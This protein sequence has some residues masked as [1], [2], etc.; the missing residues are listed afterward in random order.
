M[1]VKDG[2]GKL[3]GLCVVAGVLV[4]AIMF[5]V[6]GGLGVLS[7]K[8]SDTVNA[9]SADLVK[10]DPP[11]VT[12]VTDRNGKPIATLYDQYRIPA[13]S[14]QISNT[15]KVALISVEDARFYEHGAVDLKGTLRAAIND[16][17]GGATQGAST[18]TQQYVKNYLINVVDRNN[19]AEQAKDQAETLS[20]KLREA[21]IAIQLQQNESK[22]QILTGYLNVVAFSKN[23]YGVGAAAKV[24][25]NTTAAKLTVP[26]AALLAG[27]V[28][29]PITYNPWNH[30]Q[31][32]TKRRNLVLQRMVSQK[33]ISAAEGSKYKASGLGVV[34]SP[35]VPSSSCFGAPAY[36]GFFCNYVTT[37]LA[38]SGMPYEKLRASGDTIKTS[39]DSNLSKIARA[40]ILSQVPQ[41][42]DGVGQAFS[43]VQPG[44]T[45]HQVLAMVSNRIFHT[46]SGNGQKYSN[47]VA[48]P[49]VTFG[50][51]S[52]FKIFT[53][54]AA[55]EQGK[56]GLDTPLPNPR[57]GSFKFPHANK[58]TPLYHPQNDGRYPDPISLR[59]ALA[60]S[61]NVAFVGL[62]LKAGMP[63]VLNMASRLGLRKT[64]QANSVGT[65]PKTAVVTAYAKKNGLAS[66]YNEP[67]SQY[68][69]NQP[70]FTLGDNAVS[71]LEMSNVS[72]TIMSGGVWCPPNPILSITDRRGNPVKVPQL[73][74]EQVITPAVAHTLMQGLSQDTVSGTSAVAARAAHW[75]RPDIGKTGTT[76]TSESVAFVGGVNNYSVASM[77]WADGNHPQTLCPGTPIHLGNCGHGA[78]GGTVAA[79][80][81]FNT[82]NKVL[83]GKPNKPIPPAD[84]SML[85]AQPHGPIVPY[86]YLQNAEQAKQAL[87]K[88]GYTKVV[89]TSE[90]SAKT[91]GTVIGQS[92][93]GN[94]DKGTAITLYISTGK[95]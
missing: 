13:A 12:T 93:Q 66:A 59:D 21:R 48:D 64:M 16:V 70:S 71:P 90:P 37:Y 28:N 73:P 45:N 63:A 36:A 15:M 49:S 72:A 61:P 14:N 11:Q 5:P 26:Q 29:N 51:G 32:A 92:P 7:N 19:P 86:V 80:T 38:E 30:P 34:P 54:A 84:P 82:F 3:V 85:K 60:T 89:L 57:F 8:A 25:F 77:V 87:A 42:Q 10:V 88:A 46:G 53:T 2:L 6:V 67:Q 74:C 83:A 55:L 43:V 91:K 24:F 69:Q 95:G 47:V 22:D 23:V 52:S 4:A 35:S 50:S 41:N 33:R 31:A 76:E 81:Y 1:H 65:D 75:T 79:P 44:K 18:I 68:Q 58:Y 56:V 17:G 40:S 39:M 9:I 20:R 27:V 78:F 94:V 62:E